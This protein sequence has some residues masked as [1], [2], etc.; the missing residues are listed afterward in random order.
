[1]YG[2][3]IGCRSFG[4]LTA[5]RASAP[6]FLLAGQLQSALYYF[7]KYLL[8]SPISHLRPGKTALFDFPSV[9][10]LGD[11]MIT[12]FIICQSTDPSVS[13][14]IHRTSLNMTSL[15]LGCPVSHPFISLARKAV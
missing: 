13:V 5:W 10:P 9:L 12:T 15:L 1:M 14:L 8:L 3:K 2:A 6:P 7:K 4:A 11:N